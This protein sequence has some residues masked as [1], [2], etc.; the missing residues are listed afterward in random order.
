MRRFLLLATLLSG[1]CWAQSI[2]DSGNA[3][4]SNCSKKDAMGLVCISYVSGVTDGIMFGQVKPDGSGIDF[5]VPQG[6]TR[7]QVF[8]VVMK[9]LRDNP[10]HR[11]LATVALIQW[12]LKDAFPCTA[13]VKR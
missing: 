11:D 6:A 7:E 12:A 1:T 4:L 9:F 2:M 8:D 10:A 3:F 5:C 13:K